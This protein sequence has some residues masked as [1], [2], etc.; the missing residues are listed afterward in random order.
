MLYGTLFNNSTYSDWGIL[1][2]RLGVD[3]I[4]ADG[5]LLTELNRGSQGFIYHQFALQPLVMIAEIQTLRGN[6]LYNYRNNGLSQ[7]ANFVASSFGDFSIFMTKTS[8]PQAHNPS[9]MISNLP[10]YLDWMEI[11][12]SR[13][14]RTDLVPHI[15]SARANSP[16][17]RLTDRRFGGDMTVVWGVG[18]CEL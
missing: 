2:Y 5:V 16:N 1:Q 9:F 10:Y 13:F 14:N 3:S 7:L 8:T 6:N 11:W 12:H 18:T 4:R 15:R 17:G